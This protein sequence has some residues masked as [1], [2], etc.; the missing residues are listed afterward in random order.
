MIP[1]SKTILSLYKTVEKVEYL[2][3]VFHTN[4]KQVTK[5]SLT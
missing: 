5:I 1:K 2:N 4:S 3:S